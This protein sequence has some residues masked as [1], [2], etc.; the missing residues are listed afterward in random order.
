M[1]ESKNYYK[2]LQVDP[3]AEP[4]IITAA[5][6]RLALKYHPDIDTSPDA[7]HRMQAINEA[8]R[9]V[10]D[11]DAR[12]R[13]DQERIERLKTE[14]VKTS[15]GHEQRQAREW[16]GAEQNPQRAGNRTVEAK[17]RLRQEQERRRRDEAEVQRNWAAYERMKRSERP[18]HTEPRSDF[19]YALLGLCLAVVIFGAIL[20]ALIQPKLAE[21][22]VV[23]AGVV[24]VG[25]YYVRQRK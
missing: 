24:V 22:V 3:S 2:V 6:R 16:V 1:A 4:E 17:E 21:V 20:F 12:A 5:Y 9:V 25:W 8:Y 18:K 23:A 10:G 11:P 13:Y 14:R 7:T 19:E 15:Q